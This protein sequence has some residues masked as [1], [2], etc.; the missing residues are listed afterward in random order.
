MAK[1]FFDESYKGDLD[2]GAPYAPSL[3]P[4]MGQLSREQIIEANKRAS[5]Q[6]LPLTPEPVE[7]T[8]QKYPQLDVA[9]ENKPGYQPPIEGM[10]PTA[11]L[12]AA[13]QAAAAL[14]QPQ[15]RGPYTPGQ[16]T[17]PGGRQVLSGTDT[18]TGGI[19]LPKEYFKNMS[20]AQKAGERGLELQNEAGLVEAHANLQ[21]QR[22]NS[23]I[24]ENDQLKQQSMERQKQAD[25]TARV[26]DMERLSNDV[27]NTRIDPN[28]YWAEKGTGNQIAS[29]I[30][31]G[32]GAFGAGVTHGPNYALQIIDGAI[33]RDLHAQEANLQNKRGALATKQG[34]YN[35]ALNTYKDADTARA[36]ATAAAYTAAANKAGE[37]AA[38][39]GDKRVQANTEFLRQQLMTQANKELHTVAAAK[40]H[41]VTNETWANA[42]PTVADQNGNAPGQQLTDKQIERYVNIGPGEGGLAGNA[43]QKK[44][45][46]TKVRSAKSVLHIADQIEALRSDSKFGPLPLTEKKALLTS[47]I[48]Q[49]GQKYTTAV[50][51]GAAAEHEIEIVN[52]AAGD[53]NK[54][55]TPNVMAAIQ[56]MQDNVKDDIRLVHE[57]L[58]AIPHG[59]AHPAMATT[60]RD[61]LNPRTYAK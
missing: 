23:V 56:S 29:A 6:G 18:H 40:G 11:P 13:E 4:A 34:F 12:S 19:A 49:M 59:Y 48:K 27:M 43:E 33:Q 8:P 17:S 36:A 28:H 38:G 46:D 26:Q 9:E 24:A 53:P 3:P 14:A 35:M 31:I 22:T 47:L 30:A 55:F 2:Q 20:E 1:D 25:L 42:P 45:L 39:V 21:K 16:I 44:E 10:A 61:V 37:M 60:P 41:T 54:F 7:Y 50:G 57:G 58:E 51:G 5:G 52:A 15:A 32:L